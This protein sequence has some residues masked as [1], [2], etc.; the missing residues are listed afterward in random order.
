MLRSAGFIIVTLYDEYGDSESRIA[1]PVL[2]RDCGFKGRVLLTADKEMIS[3]WAE[4]IAEAEI[5]VFVVTNN[6]EGPRQWGPRI[7]AARKFIARELKRRTK[8]FSALISSD[9]RIS[10]VRIYADGNWRT[11]PVPRKNPPHENKYKSKGNL[12]LSS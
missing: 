7:V 6:D 5:A 9:G 3:T 11:I 1:D 8:P 4:E 12:P 2:I 10:Q